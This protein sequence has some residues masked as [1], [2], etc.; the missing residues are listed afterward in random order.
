MKKA[1]LV[2]KS[3]FFYLFNIHYRMRGV[4]IGRNSLIAPGGDFFFVNLKGLQ[5]GDN[6]LI[7]RNSWISC[8]SRNAKIKISHLTRIG[9]GAVIAALG[10]ITIGSNVLISYRV[11]IIDHQHVLDRIKS[12]SSRS[13]I[14]KNA[15]IVISDG[16]FIGAGSFIFQGVTLG[17]GCIVGANSV[18]TKSFPPNSIICGSPAKQIGFTRKKSVR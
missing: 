12:S 10:N 8:A 5:I 13:G 3:I 17:E 15:D 18:V 14:G 9:R 16:V 2:L 1:K 6:T 4:K 11:S 7:A